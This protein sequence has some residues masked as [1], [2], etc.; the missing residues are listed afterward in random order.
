MCFCIHVLYG[1]HGLHMDPKGLRWKSIK[2]F[3]IDRKRSLCVLDCFSHC[4]NT[5]NVCSD[6]SRGAVSVGCWWM[7]LGWCFAWLWH[8]QLR[9]QEWV[10]PSPSVTLRLHYEQLHCHAHWIYFRVSRC[11]TD[12]SA[13]FDVVVWAPVEIIWF[14]SVVQWLRRWTCT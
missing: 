11:S 10:R 5:V 6:V 7:C 4:Q 8:C 3:G 14:I 13:T 12:L 9:C 2:P 1:H